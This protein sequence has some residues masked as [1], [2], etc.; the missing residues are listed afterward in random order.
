[1]RVCR[2]HGWGESV[3]YIIHLKSSLDVVILTRILQPK[4]NFV[5]LTCQ[6]SNQQNTLNKREHV[7]PRAHRC[8][9][10]VSMRR[11]PQPIGARMLRD[12]RHATGAFTVQV[13]EHVCI[14][15]GYSSMQERGSSC[16][17]PCSS[18]R[19]RHVMIAQPLRFQHGRTINKGT[20]QLFQRVRS[21]IAA[22][23]EVLDIL[24]EC[25]QIVWGGGSRKTIPMKTV[26][27]QVIHP[28]QTDQSF[29]TT[30]GSFPWEA[31]RPEG[32]RKTVLWRTLL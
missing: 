23:D 15:R 21:L 25:M 8:T 14:V 32:A 18:A 19:S 2:R 28:S 24:Q 22:R 6:A 29:S 26:Q 16:P 4:S 7:S 10:K 12:R 17:P 31:L 13:I 5:A 1:M 3:S 11:T 9:Y 20:P 27:S 30:L